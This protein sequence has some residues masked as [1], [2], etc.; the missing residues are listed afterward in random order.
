MASLSERLKAPVKGFIKAIKIKA[1]KIREKRKNVL[2]PYLNFSTKVSNN[3]PVNTGI[4][5]VNDGASD[6]IYP[7]K[8]TVIKTKAF[9]M[10][11]RYIFINH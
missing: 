2:L 7:H 8:P 6:A 1:V 9:I 11:I 5:A 4:R 10:L 3:A